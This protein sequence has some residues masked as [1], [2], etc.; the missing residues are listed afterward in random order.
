MKISSL[1]INVETYTNHAHWQ[2]KE[3]HWL[4][5]HAEGKKQM[6]LL[7]N[8]P[9][10]FALICHLLPSLSQIRK[11]IA[12]HHLFLCLISQMSYIL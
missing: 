8:S 10:L 4:N 2:R 5:R 1:L 9:L 3:I 7:H 11:Q 12:I 6:V